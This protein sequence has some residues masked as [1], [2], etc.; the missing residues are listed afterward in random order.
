MRVFDKDSI[1][2]GQ[3]ESGDREYLVASEARQYWVSYGLVGY[4]ARFRMPSA[5]TL[6]RGQLVLL[7]S[8]RGVETG[9]VL[10]PVDDKPYTAGPDS[11]KLLTLLHRDKPTGD[12]LRPLAEG[13]PFLQEHKRRLREIA[14][15]LESELRAGRDPGLVC[16]LECVYQPQRLGLLYL[17]LLP[18]TIA[19]LSTLLERHFQMPTEWYDAGEWLDADQA[20][21][22]RLQAGSRWFPARDDAG[23][24]AC[25]QGQCACARVAPRQVS[26]GIGKCGVRTDH[27]VTAQSATDQMHGG[28]SGC[29]IRD[30]FSN[31]TRVQAEPATSS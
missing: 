25:N 30:W 2:S 7:R 8:H 21:E 5:T 10:W 24:S 19:R 18:A 4:C 26:P 20:W 12:I 22:Q 3:T 14:E 9:R 16:D 31:A 27:T 17:G 1:Q 23:R 11:R 6:E 28:C 13:D 15:W 29:M